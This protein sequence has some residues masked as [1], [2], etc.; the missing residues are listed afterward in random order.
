MGTLTSVTMATKYFD[1][2][3]ILIFLYVPWQI[4]NSMFLVVI[5]KLDT[6]TR[7]HFDAS[8]SHG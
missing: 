3:D 2:M 1:S 4:V 6:H 5:T 8:L 7:S